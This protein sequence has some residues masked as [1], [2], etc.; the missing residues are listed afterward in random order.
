[1]TS[2]Q[3]NKQNLSCKISLGIQGMDCPDCAMKLEKGISGMPGVDSVNVDFISGKMTAIGTGISESDIAG[4]VKSLGYRAVSYGESVVDKDEIDRKTRKRQLIEVVAAGILAIA[5]GILLHTEGFSL[6]GKILILSGIVISGNNIGRKGYLALRKLRLDMNFLM[7]AAVIGAILIGEWLEGGVVIILFAIAQLLESY[8]LARSNRAV[9]SLM[10][11]SPKKA[12]V[13]RNGEEI[14][15]DIQEI[16]IG[17]IVSVKP[18]EQIPVDGNVTGGFSS[19]N[20]ATITG[21][22][23]PVSKK[24]GDPV[25]AGTINGDGFLEI[26]TL[27]NPDDF[28]LSRIVRLVEEARAKRAPSQSFVDKF[29]AIYTPIVTVLAVLV[30]IIPPL[31]FNALWIE[32]IYRALALLVIACP[33]ALVI[34]T[35]VT[36]VSALTN[37]AR[38]GVLIKGG[39]FIENLHKIRSVA[40]DKTGTITR[41]VL[42]VHKIIGLDNKSEEE[43]L[44]IAA[45][46]EKM[47]QHPIGDAIVRYAEEKGISLMPVQE[48]RS[49]PGKGACGIVDGIEICVG[50]PSLFEGFGAIKEG[51]FQSEIEKEARTVVVLGSKE[52]ALG[53]IFISDTIRPESI[54]VVRQLMSL[55]V[56]NTV[57]VTGDNDRIAAEVGKEVG[58]DETRADLMP[59]D[60]VGFIENLKNRHDSVVMIGD[61]V[62]DAPALAASDIGIAMGAIG[63]DVALETADIALMSDDLSRIPWAY[64][65]SKK[66]YQII[67]ANI[68]MAIGIKAV[69]IGLASAGLATLWMAVFAD[70]GVSLMVII[71]G[72]R[73]LKLR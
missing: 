39:I 50:S 9:K 5:G 41:G 68:V 40:F 23:I 8:S 37:A 49:M 58:V 59:E 45:S 34:S 73:A 52:K 31:L 21:E 7:S 53:F 28:K 65:L 42:S 2:K 70:M 33:C 18:G 44:R 64:R 13:K 6:I 11:L 69:F 66:A 35:P 61:G 25:Y 55:G 38:N 51:D 62:N 56:A 43:I 29:A 17:D 16:I 60:K 12:V 71:N 1:M 57:M 4:E 24:A 48:F 19:V 36:V 10:D 30:A 32:W 63:S 14:I 67:I 26:K 47:S 27:K 15:I 20:Q 22:S 3:D 46:I 54:A 72:M